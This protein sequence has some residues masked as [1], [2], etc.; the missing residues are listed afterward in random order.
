MGFFRVKLFIRFLD[1][2]VLYLRRTNGF[3]PKFPTLFLFK[4]NQVDSD[5]WTSAC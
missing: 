2:R 1:P 5:G 4:R 3:S